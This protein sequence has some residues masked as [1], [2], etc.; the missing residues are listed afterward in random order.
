M[1]RWKKLRGPTGVHAA[2]SDGRAAGA[3]EAGQGIPL[4]SSFSMACSR[5]YRH[6]VLVHRGI[7][8]L[9]Y[10]SVTQLRRMKA[11]KHVA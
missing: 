10:R 5:M 7:L 8:H 4:A 3:A 2:G 9:G 1:G 6:L 11:N